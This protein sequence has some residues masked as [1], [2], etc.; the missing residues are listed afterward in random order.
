MAVK[1]D[2]M[3][4]VTRSSL[5]DTGSGRCWFLG[6]LSRSE[7]FSF[8]F[9]SYGSSSVVIKLLITHPVR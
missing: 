5:P 8:V 9:R 1:D 3:S 6:S 2:M 7:D 4:V